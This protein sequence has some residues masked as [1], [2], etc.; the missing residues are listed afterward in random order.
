MGKKVFGKIAHKRLILSHH[1]NLN[2]G[3][4]LIDDRTVNGASLF[5]GEHIHFGTDGFPDWASVCN[6]LL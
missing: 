4:F 3:D 2:L 6:Y 1:K 5:Q